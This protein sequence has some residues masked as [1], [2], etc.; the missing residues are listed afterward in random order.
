MRV[1][2]LA[3]N[4]TERGSAIRA[5]SLARWLAQQGRDVVL[6]SGR[7]EPGLSWTSRALDG[8]RMVEP[9][10]VLPYRLRNGGLSPV[11]LA[12]RLAHVARE[13]Y[14]VVHTFEP[15]P[16]STLPGLLARRRRAALVADWADLWGLDGMAG[17]WPLPQR[18]TLGAVDDVL[19][20]FTRR[21]ADAV[22]VISSD[23]ERRARA[24]GIPQARI[25]R[26]GVGANDDLFRPQPPAAARA[27]LGLPSDALVLVHTG[28]APFDEHLLA[29][30]FERVAALEPR[31]HL[32][33]SGR[34]FPLVD[35]RA[36]FAGAAARVHHVGVVPYSELGTVMA[37]GDVMV[38]PYSALPHN[39]A[40][41]PNRLGDYLAAGRPVATNPTGD[42]SRLVADERVGIVAPAAPEAFAQALVDLLHDAELRGEMGARARTLAETTLSWRTLAAGVGELYD[43]LVSAVT[44]PRSRSSS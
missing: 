8:V 37:A 16:A 4:V 15:R 20:R 19:Q 14:D 38:V 41:F 29:H 33:L 42:L 43:E 36:A 34:R 44:G 1:L 7:S 32:L 30:T 13:R 40:R 27:R 26:V 39:E 22:T 2:M 28:F 21:S 31:A 12:A 35:E 3:H 24:L 18:F 6:V 23:L 11:D 25:R 9:P 17:T 5:W 10:D